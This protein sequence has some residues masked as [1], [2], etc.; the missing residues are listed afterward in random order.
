MEERS[1]TVQISVNFDQVEP[2]T[3]ST[4]FEH[5]GCQAPLSGRHSQH[6]VHVVVVSARDRAPFAQQVCNGFPGP[7]PCFDP[8]R[9]GRL[10]QRSHHAHDSC[11]WCTSTA[12]W[13]SPSRNFLEQAFEVLA[14]GIPAEHT[15][16]IASWTDD[17][18]ECIMEMPRRSI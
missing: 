14:A 11:C 13:V 7:E 2:T 9:F 1:G 3:T 6:D 12:S 16:Q 15:H 18:G 4:A 5:R 10:S 8:L 17:V